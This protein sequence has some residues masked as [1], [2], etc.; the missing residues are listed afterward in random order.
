VNERRKH[1]RRTQDIRVRWQIVGEDAGR[2]E[3]APGPSDHESSVT[4][5]FSERGLGIVA[6]AP[7]DADTVI[8]LELERSG[9]GPPLSALGRVVRCE[10]ID[11]GFLLGV[12]LTWI[13]CTSP[14]RALG[15]AP[16]T[17]WTLL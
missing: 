10:P 15:L 4:R 11:D 9:G 7:V 16:V 2:A 8:A 14:E 3:R 13:E 1:P 6:D 17:A 12:E 5:D